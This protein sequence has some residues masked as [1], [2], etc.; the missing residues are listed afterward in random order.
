MQYAQVSASE[1]LEA[2][3]CFNSLYFHF[4]IL[5]SN[6]PL[7][8]NFLNIMPLTLVLLLILVVLRLSL[9]HSIIYYS[10]IVC[11]FLQLAMVQQL[12]S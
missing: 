12:Y 7:C 3:Y 10:I 4:V 9:F 2:F 5:E 6:P 1:I 8:Y 11:F